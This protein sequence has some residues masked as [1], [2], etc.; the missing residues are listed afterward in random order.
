MLILPIVIDVAY[1]KVCWTKS[2]S[3]QVCNCRSV[4][5]PECPKCSSARVPS[6][7]SS[8]LCVLMCPSAL[9]SLIWMFECPLSVFTCALRAWMSDQ[10]WLEQ[11]T[12]YKKMFYVYEK[13]Q[14]W[15]RRFWGT[16][17]WS[18]N[19]ALIEKDFESS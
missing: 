17:F 5:V 12:R 2:S 13:K 1:G 15:L 6:E 7:W 16:S 14:K 3:A 8:V 10:I 19:R 11:N 4:R 9:K 18:R